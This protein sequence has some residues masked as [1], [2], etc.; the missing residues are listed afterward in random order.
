MKTALLSYFIVL[1]N[2]IA[3]FMFGHCVQLNNET[4]K[5]SNILYFENKLYIY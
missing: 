1:K 3:D 2:N 5:I 4:I